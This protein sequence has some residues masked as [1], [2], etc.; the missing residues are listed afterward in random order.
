MARMNITKSLK[1]VILVGSCCAFLLI[2]NLASRYHNSVYQLTPLDRLQASYESTIASVSTAENIILVD[3]QNCFDVNVTSGNAS[4]D[5]SACLNKLIIGAERAEEAA[6]TPGEVNS[7][8]NSSTLATSVKRNATGT[9]RDLNLLQSW[10]NAS[11]SSATTTTT[12][13][14]R[15]LSD[16]EG[17]DHFLRHFNLTSREG[18]DPINNLN[19]MP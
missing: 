6:V 14:G 10:L 4:I 18:F 12:A 1:A 7:E 16:A 2:Q 3:Y 19:G 13:D 9:F 8:N 5:L 15:L 11:L 17:Y